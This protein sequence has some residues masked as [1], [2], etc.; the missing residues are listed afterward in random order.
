MVIDESLATTTTDEATITTTTDEAIITSTTDE[1]TITSTTD[2]ATITTTTGDIIAPEIRDILLDLAVAHACSVSASVGLGMD[3]FMRDFA[4]HLGTDTSMRE[5]AGQ[6]EHE[7]GFRNNY[8]R[9]VV[10]RS[11]NEAHERGWALRA[12]RLAG[13]GRYVDVDRVS[14]DRSG[15]LARLAATGRRVDVSSLDCPK[16]L[17]EEDDFE[18]LPDLEEIP[19]EDSYRYCRKHDDHSDSD[20]EPL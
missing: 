2:E 3:A 15:A 12:D 8:T 11:D 20:D 10:G 19:V 18:D 6:V 9:V 4:G 16:A 13:T 1:A 14:L 7:V 5:V 17:A